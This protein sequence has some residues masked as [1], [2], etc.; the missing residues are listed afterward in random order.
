MAEPENPFEKYVTPSAVA[1]V[2][3]GPEVNP[4]AKY[5]TPD[6]SVLESFLRGGAEGATFGFDDK[7]GLDKER[8]EASRKAN[9]WTHFMG[10]MAG[11][12][13]PMAVATPLAAVRGAG[14]A[15]RVA[16]GVA[17]PLVPGEMATLGQSIG[18]GAKLGVTYGA[19]SGAGHA[20]VKEDDSLVQAGLKRAGGALQP[21]PQHEHPHREVSSSGLDDAAT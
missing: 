2:P 11:T 4:F 17:T 13:L 10:E 14:I 5:V 20:D 1:P 19:L 15:A 3:V 8:R 16:R 6:V 12:V 9:P 18:Q 21:R 7:L